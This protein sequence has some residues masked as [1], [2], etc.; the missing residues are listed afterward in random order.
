LAFSRYFIC[1]HCKR[2]L[3]FALVEHIVFN[4]RL[5]ILYHCRCDSTVRRESFAAVPE[6]L[7]RLTQP[8]VLSLPYRAAPAPAERLTDELERTI[9][10]F[11]RRM[12]RC[13]DVAGF[14]SRIHE[15]ETNGD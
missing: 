1:S 9:A 13:N 4:G 8:M 10:A 7:A 12:R 5:D 6:A 11:G 2:E 15:D 14:L 3:E